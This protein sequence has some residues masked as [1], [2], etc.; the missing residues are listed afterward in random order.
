MCVKDVRMDDRFRY[1]VIISDV[2]HG[3]KELVAV[4]YIYSEPLRRVSQNY[5]W[6]FMHGAIERL[7]KDW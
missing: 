1:L 4:E 7:S 2:E 3:R 5:C 6:I